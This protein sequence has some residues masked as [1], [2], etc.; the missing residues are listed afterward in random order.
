MKRIAMACVAGA[1]VAVPAFGVSAKSAQHAE[2]VHLNK[3]KPNATKQLVFLEALSSL[4]NG[5]TISKAT[6]NFVAVHPQWFPAKAK[7]TSYNAKINHALTIPMLLKD[8][9]SYAS[10]LYR[11]TAS[12]VE[13]HQYHNPNYAIVQVMIDSGSEE[14]DSAVIMYE[15]TTG[16]IV[17]DSEIQFVGLPVSEWDFS[18]VSGGTTQAI[19]FDGV[20]L[21]LLS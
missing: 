17:Q 14:G 15:G 12:V 21:R 11:N 5:I 7:D 3:A 16:S 6:K 4:G 8:P 10:E 1:L 18:N 9:T 13:I 2:T 19:L 20:S